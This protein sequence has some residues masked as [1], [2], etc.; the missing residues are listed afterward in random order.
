MAAMVEMARRS[1]SV[2]G[3]GQTATLMRREKPSQEWLISQIAFL[4]EARQAAVNPQTFTVFATHLSQYDLRDISV[5]VRR[6]SLQRRSEGETAFPDLGTVDEAVKDERNERMRAE[7]KRAEREEE[8][9]E[10]R[11]RREHPE[12][13]APFDLKAEYAKIRARNG[14]AVQQA[15]ET[16]RREQR[17]PTCGAVP[18][19][20]YC[21][22]LT[23]QQ[24][25]ELAN[26]LERQ[27]SGR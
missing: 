6:L 17:C 20:T 10:E 12:K 7:R 8:E 15:R 22:S 1:N 13:Y 23:P 9:A 3:R 14:E 18:G 5:A 16:M 2:D 4:A 21:Q 11:D 27:E 25:R 26:V 24:L 19:A